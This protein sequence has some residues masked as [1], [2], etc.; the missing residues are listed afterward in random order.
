MKFHLA[1]CLPVLAAAAKYSKDDYASGQVHMDSIAR[2]QASWARQRESGEM[3]SSQYTSW[4]KWGRKGNWRQRRDHV[5]C[6]NGQA[7][8][9]RGNP[10]Q[11]FSC[12]GL[13][14]Y[15]FKSHADLG[16]WAGEGSDTWGWVADDGR[17]FI[18]I[19][20]AD[21]T[22]FAEIDKRGKLIYL[23]R[24][25]QQSVASIWHDIKGGNALASW[26]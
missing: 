10:N 21:G 20:Q 17:E 15:D 13:D 6:V 5:P 14:L 4:D 18:A 24:L 1:L 9:E 11:T 22:A 25:P 2:K 26:Y 12:N 16:S 7:V 8:V 3:D 23:G 19:G